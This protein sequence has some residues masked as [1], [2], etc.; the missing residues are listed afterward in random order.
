MSTGFQ[1]QISLG[2]NTLCH[3]GGVPVRSWFFSRAA[4]FVT[5]LAAM[6]FLPPFLQPFLQPFLHSNI[7]TQAQQIT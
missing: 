2:A 5:N 1:P 6:P 3:I 4:I 7:Y